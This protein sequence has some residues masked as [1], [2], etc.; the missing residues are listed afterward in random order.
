[1]LVFDDNRPQFVY[2]H[3]SLLELI[4]PCRTFRTLFDST[5][6]DAA[7]ANPAKMQKKGSTPSSTGEPKW[8]LMKGIGCK[9]AVIKVPAA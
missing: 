4:R 2:P 3:V 7:G 1:M 9:A 6:F 8:N 5:Y